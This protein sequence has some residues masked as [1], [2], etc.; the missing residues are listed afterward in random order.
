MT[1]CNRLTGS[2]RPDPFHWIVKKNQSFEPH[3]HIWKNGEE[4]II[5]QESWVVINGSVECTFYD[6]DN[7]I[8][9][10]PIL[11]KGDCSVTLEGGHT[12]TILEENTLVYEFKTGPY[13]GQKFDKVLLN[14]A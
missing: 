8:L 2:S 4:E 3:F 13:K 5:A 10:R 7:K 12:Y 6:L 14:E 11:E 9:A 1:W